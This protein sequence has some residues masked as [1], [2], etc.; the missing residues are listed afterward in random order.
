MCFAF[1]TRMDCLALLVDNFLTISKSSEVTLVYGE[2]NEI[3][4]T[5]P[6][7]ICC[8]CAFMSSVF[9]PSHLKS[10][11][12]SY[13]IWNNGAKPKKRLLSHWFAWRWFFPLNNIAWSRDEILTF[14]LFESSK[15]SGS[16]TTVTC[17]LNVWLSLNLDIYRLKADTY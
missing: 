16:K 1:R 6:S 9:V 15:N 10:E 4:Y 8:I 14:P 12:N 5:I 17:E 7:T 11:N 13:I 2:Q 3:T